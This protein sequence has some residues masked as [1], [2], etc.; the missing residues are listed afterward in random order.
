[1]CC[2]LSESKIPCSHLTWF[3]CAKNRAKKEKI[4]ETTNVLCGTCN[5]IRAE[6]TD[7]STSILVGIG[8]QINFLPFPFVRKQWIKVWRHFANGEVNKTSRRTHTY[9]RTR[10]GVMLVGDG[11]S[12]PDERNVEWDVNMWEMVILQPRNLNFLGKPVT[13]DYDPYSFP[14][15]PLMFQLWYSLSHT[16]TLM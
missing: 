4:R 6:E 5:P 2:V 9:I 1:M 15:L 8:V 13:R 12:N 16:K 10:R 11:E 14:R 3:R 7:D